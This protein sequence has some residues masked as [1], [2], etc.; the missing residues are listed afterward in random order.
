MEFYIIAQ[1]GVAG[2]LAEQPH[3]RMVFDDMKRENRP[4]VMVYRLTLGGGRVRYIVLD[5]HQRERVDYKAIMERE[6]QNR[7]D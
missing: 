6:E 7:Q 1:W 4:C 5:A 3:A 2:R